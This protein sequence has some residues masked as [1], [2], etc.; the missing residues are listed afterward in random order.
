[1]PVAQESSLNRDD[2]KRMAEVLWSGAM[3]KKPEAHLTG[4]IVRL[5]NM[6]R[7][8]LGAIANLLRGN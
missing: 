4:K 3:G 1:M 8:C 2:A 7:G 6:W 5:M